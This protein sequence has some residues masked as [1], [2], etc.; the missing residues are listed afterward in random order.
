MWNF[1]TRKAF[2]KAGLQRLAC[3]ALILGGAAYNHRQQQSTFPF[4]LS[5]CASSGPEKNLSDAELSSLISNKVADIREKYK[6]K[7]PGCLE[8]KLLVWSVSGRP[9]TQSIE[10]K[11]P[12]AGGDVVGVMAVWLQ[13]LSQQGAVEF[14]SQ[15]DDGRGGKVISFVASGPDK[16]GQK[17]I[18]ESGSISSEYITL[19]FGVLVN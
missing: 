3:P 9:H 14:H 10:L 13:V 15:A 1:L 6:H 7:H 8:S 19:L 2:A 4:L 17:S 18:E 12:S 16:S 11:L 5:S